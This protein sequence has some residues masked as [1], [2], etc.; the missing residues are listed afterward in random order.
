MIA[1]TAAAQRPCRGEVACGD[2]FLVLDGP[3]TLV[4]LVDGL[5]HGPRAREAAMR[6]LELAEQQRLL[7]PQK[8]FEAGC[9][10]L[11]GTRGVAA[12]VAKLD[13]VA[14]TIDVSGVGNIELRSISRVPIT[15][16]STPGIVGRPVR[17]IREYRYPL[18]SGDLLVLSSDGISRR[19]EIARY[20]SLEPEAM[21]Q[22]WLQEYGSAHDDV[23]CLVVRMEDG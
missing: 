21:A 12:M 17:T 1:R 3:I 23:T 22:A 9:S 14:G 2:G 8:I 20:A 19:A 16:I 15:P 4:A 10:A 5:G 18:S 7:S 13:C 6:F 11:S